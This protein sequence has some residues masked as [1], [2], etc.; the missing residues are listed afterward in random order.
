MLDVTL[1]QVASKRRRNSGRP[2]IL[3]SRVV[4]RLMSLTHPLLHPEHRHC[5]PPPAPRRPGGSS[6]WR[7]GGRGTAPRRHGPS[8]GVLPETRYGGPKPFLQ[9]GLPVQAYEG[10][11]LIYRSMGKI[12]GAWWYYVGPP[13][14]PFGDILLVLHLSCLLYP[15]LSLPPGEISHWYTSRAAVAK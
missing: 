11:H 5:A 6:E 15:P 14:I 12:V 1:L 10:P 2:R 9:E 3:V 4:G 8:H 7:T 13:Q